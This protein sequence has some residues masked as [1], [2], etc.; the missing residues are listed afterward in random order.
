MQNQPDFCIYLS[1]IGL[2]NNCFKSNA[3]LQRDFI[4]LDLGP[5]LEAS[6]YGRNK[7]QLMTYDDQRPNLVNWVN[8]VL[9]D[10]DAAKYV[11]GSAFHWYLNNDTN[12]VNLDEVHSL[13]PTKFILNTEASETWMGYPKKV[14]LGSWYLFE[15]YANDIIQVFTQFKFHNNKGWPR[16]L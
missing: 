9:A 3:S 6:D 1:Q 2:R 11:S 12:L 7:L 14:Y 4:K 5:I 10:K 16:G 8:T 15:G 13:Y